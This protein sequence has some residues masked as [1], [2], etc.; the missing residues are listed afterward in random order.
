MTSIQDTRISQVLRL[1][2]Q[3]PVV[4]IYGEEG[5]GKTYLAKKIAEM[6]GGVYINCR[7]IIKSRILD[8]LWD[9]IGH[10][11][12]GASRPSTLT[13]LVEVLNSMEEGGWRVIVSMDNISVKSVAEEISRYRGKNFAFLAV[14]DSPDFV[15]NY[16]PVVHLDPLRISSSL[17]IM[18]WRSMV[19]RLENYAVCGGYPGRIKAFH[20][21]GTLLDSILNNFMTKRAYFYD[22]PRR[23]LGKKLRELSTYFDILS[24]IGAESVEFSKICD[25]VYIGKSSAIKYLN[26]LVRMGV[27]RREKSIGG[28]RGAYKISD[29]SLRFWFSFVYPNIG[30]IESGDRGYCSK[31]L[32]RNFPK[33]MALV[34]SDIFREIMRDIAENTGLLS[35]GTPFGLWWE[36][37]DRID[38]IAYDKKK[39]RVLLGIAKWSDKKMTMRD[40]SFIYSFIFGGKK[41]RK[42]VALF[43]R[44]GFD[45]ALISLAKQEGFLLY[46]PLSVARVFKIM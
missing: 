29:F 31:Y 11:V 13:H 39:R 17:K 46:T 8:A 24:A 42:I 5:V 10:R 40:I 1:V 7:F 18:R 36:G 34:I 43:S 35:P 41:S 15:G 19:A 2:S 44:A 20:G 4:F 23:V 14:I 37:E 12:R 28:G 26:T 21:G 38:V 45:S 30:A 25:R 27:V 32:K 3:N 33:Y 9:K 6:L 16:A 22:F